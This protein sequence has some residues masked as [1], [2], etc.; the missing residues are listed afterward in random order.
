MLRSRLAAIGN[1]LGPPR[2]RGLGRF[3]GCGMRKAG[4]F[5]SADQWCNLVQRCTVPDGGVDGQ[6]HQNL[7]FHKIELFLASGGPGGSG[8]YPGIA[9]AGPEHATCGGISRDLRDP[10]AQLDEWIDRSTPEHH[11]DG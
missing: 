11:D 6:R 5:Q 1:R 4:W 9:P 2:C 3:A 10:G 8:A 7:V